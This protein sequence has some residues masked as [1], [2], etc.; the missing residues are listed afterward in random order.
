MFLT[1]R[2]KKESAA[3]FRAKIVFAWRAASCVR[4]RSQLLTEPLWRRGEAWQFQR[5][6][7]A[8]ICKFKL[9]RYR[10]QQLKSQRTNHPIPEHMDVVAR[11]AL[12]LPPLSAASGASPAAE[13]T[14]SARSDAHQSR[15]VSQQLTSPPQFTGFNLC[16]QKLSKFKFRSDENAAWNHLVSFWLYMRAPDIWEK[17]TL[18]R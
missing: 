8:Q 18:H 6:A 9:P 5:G 14:R 3:V 7:T 12:F 11:R 17:N 10:Q 4:Y 15:P 2:G 13:G 1:V 16:C